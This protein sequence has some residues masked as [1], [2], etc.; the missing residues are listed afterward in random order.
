MT[1]TFP[2]ADSLAYV[3]LVG[4][5]AS[6]NQ[7]IGLDLAG[8]GYQTIVVDT[9]AQAQKRIQQMRPSMVIVNYAKLGQR[10][11]DFCRGLRDKQMVQPILFVVAQ[12]Q[13]ADRVVCLEAGADDYLLQAYRQE[14]FLQL[15][16]VYLQPKTNGQREQLLFGD[17]ILDLNSRSVWRSPSGIEDDPPQVIE[18]T[19]KEFELLKYLMSYPQQTLTREQILKNVWGDDFQGESN[20]IEVYIRYLRLKIEKKGGK[21]LI[22]TVRGVGYVLKDA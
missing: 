5:T 2:T 12:D 4:T 17:L 3:L 8:S 10:G 18:L 19:V 6:F 16:S 21:R 14:K 9:P 22:Q 13:V 1:Q 20:V 11:I 15:L 7:Q